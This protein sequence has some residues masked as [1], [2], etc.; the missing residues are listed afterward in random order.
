[1]RP[2]GLSRP[3]KQRAYPALVWDA[4]LCDSLL[5]PAAELK[6]ARISGRLAQLVRALARQARGHWFESSIAHL[7]PE[8]WLRLVKAAQ[9]GDSLGCRLQ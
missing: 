9:F 2:I 4:K 8:I 7:R 3:E 1:M 5:L 6:T